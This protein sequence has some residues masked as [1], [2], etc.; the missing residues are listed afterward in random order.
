MNRKYVAQVPRQKPTDPEVFFNRRQLMA[1]ALTRLERYHRLLTTMVEFRIEKGQ[2][3]MQVVGRELDTNDPVDSVIPFTLQ[4]CRLSYGDNLTPLRVELT[5]DRPKDPSPIENFFRSQVNY[6]SSEN[7][8]LFR[9]SDLDVRLKGS[10]TEVAV[11][12][13]TVIQNYLTRYDKNDTVSLVRK[14]V[15]ETLV[16]GELSKQSIAEA[17]NLS[18]RTLQR[19]LE[20][21]RSSVKEI[22]DDTRHQMALKYLD[23]K[24]HSIKEISFNLGFSD[25]SNFS[26]AFKRWEG[27]TP[28]QY[29]Q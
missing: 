11:A 9:T 19:R 22:I 29:R 28:K 15:A 17:M 27:K 12:M 18:A 23:Q 3:T 6:S 10:N 4:I 8:L 14:V 24:N 13:D 20:E 7:V 5:C 26:R 16:N 25:S 1:G 21:Q 2:G